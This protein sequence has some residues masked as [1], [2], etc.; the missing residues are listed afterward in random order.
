MDN[1]T[2]VNPRKENNDLGDLKCSFCG[3]QTSAYIALD[4]NQICKGCLFKLIDK[5][6]KTILGRRKCGR[7]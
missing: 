5:I 2:I 3:C 4:K 6:D 7:N 1:A